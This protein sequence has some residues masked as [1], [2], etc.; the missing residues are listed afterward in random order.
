MDLPTWTKVI[1]NTGKLKA[2]SDF[3]LLFKVNYE[4]YLNELRPYKRIGE[5]KRSIVIT[6]RAKD[7][8]NHTDVIAIVDKESP[9]LVYSFVGYEIH[10]KK[11]VVHFVYTKPEFRK[12]DF[13]FNLLCIIEKEIN[14][15]TYSMLTSK[16]KR[17]GMFKKYKMEIMK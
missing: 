1:R 12:N 6:R 5:N 14:K 2:I 16:P 8:Y 10:G 13:C 17:Y 9:N 11:L 3:D 4:D 15:F 7:I